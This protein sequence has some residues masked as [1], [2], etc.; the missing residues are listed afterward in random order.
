MKMIIKAYKDK[1]GLNLSKNFTSLDQIE[2]E[3][4]GQFVGEL[5]DTDLSNLNVDAG[6]EAVRQIGVT[7]LRHK[8]R[9]LV[10]RKLATG[11]ELLVY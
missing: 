11:L 3:A 4:L 9:G 1:L 6:V 2:I 7:E 10:Q 8:P 5:N